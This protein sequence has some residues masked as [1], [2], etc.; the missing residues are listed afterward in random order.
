MDLADF[1]QVWNCAKLH[2]LASLTICGGRVTHRTPLFFGRGIDL[3]ACYK[4]A[5]NNRNIRRDGPVIASQMWPN[6]AIDRLRDIAQCGKFDSL[7][8][9][10][11]PSCTL[12]FW[13]LSR[14]TRHLRIPEKWLEY[15]YRRQRYGEPNMAR[16]R[17]IVRFWTFPKV[18]P[19]LTT[20][21]FNLQVCTLA[22]LQYPRPSREAPKM[23]GIG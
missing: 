11:F 21:V 9:G 19:L 13:V 15:L 7:W 2:D 5:K 23:M 14:H 20:S 10:R 22:V 16:R 8:W 18:W 17:A 6:G 12:D 3:S 1:S 4:S